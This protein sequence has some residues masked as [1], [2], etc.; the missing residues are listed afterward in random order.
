VCRRESMLSRPVSVSARELAGWL[1]LESLW[2]ERLA[3][4]GELPA[5]AGR[6][7]YSFDPRCVYE[8]LIDKQPDLTEGGHVDLD[9]LR[10][11]SAALSSGDPIRSV[12]GRILERLLRTLDAECGAIFLSDDEA[13][14]QEVVSSGVSDEAGRGL[15]QGVAVWAG[16]NREPLLLPDPR[17][18]SGSLDLSGAEVVDL[19]TSEGPRDAMAVPFLIE[20]RVMGVLVAIRGREAPTFAKAHLALASI[21]ATELALAV[22]RSRVH[23]A[24][25]HRLSVAQ[26]QLEV[27]ARDVR[28]LFGAE[29]QRAEQ[30]AIALS[31][32]ERTYLATV[33]GLAAAVEAKD[34]YT[35]GHLVR[36]TRYGM[37]MLE[38]VAGG[39]GDDPSYEY[40]FLLH[41]V[42][43]LGIP[44]RI[45]TKNGPLTGDE[46]EYMRRHPEIGVRILSDIPFLNGA[47]EI[48]HAHHERWD[49]TGYP[50]GLGGEEIPVGARLFAVADAFDAMTTD[51]PYRRALPL[52]AA[53]GELRL[54]AGSQ[55]WPDAVDALLS[56]PRAMLEETS[57]SGNG[58]RPH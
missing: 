54:R 43:K 52:E 56:L 46:W 38:E 40:G 21:I 16:A 8:W 32:V 1:G 45:L 50:Y 20:G 5:T 39:G 34:E 42:G 6:K 49:G 57:S 11:I 41:D 25:T 10:D 2:L 27:Y 23:E 30:L 47:R 19:S 26:T 7:G 3:D 13:W 15:L 48:V 18:I 37:S 36:V 51:R 4:Q 28:E 33:K 53:I 55:F 12:C 58:H 9:S 14:L 44:D 35:A 31:E 24:L 17:R 22:E 29:K